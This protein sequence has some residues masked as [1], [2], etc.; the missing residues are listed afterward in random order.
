[1]PAERALVEAAAESGCDLILTGAGADS[2]FEGE[3]A[4]LADDLLRHPWRTLGLV[5]RYA[6]SRLMPAWRV[7][8]EEIWQRHR[9]MLR[10]RAPA[11]IRPEF[12]A[13]HPEIAVASSG[14]NRRTTPRWSWLIL[15]RSTAAGSLSWHADMAAIRRSIGD[16]TGWHLAEPRGILI[17]RPFLDPSLIRWLMGLPRSFRCHPEVRKL[18]LRRATERI[19]PPLIR[20]RQAKIPMDDAVVAG[21]VAATD[22]I[23][24]RFE[25]LPTTLEA[26]LDPTPL[27][28]LLDRARV[29]LAAAPE[30]V[31][32]A[33]ALALVEWC[34]GR[35]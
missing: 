2:F 19:L 4:H 1:M 16:R 35:G 26:V 5:R 3:P 34:R 20:D 29:G 22:S 9:S 17:S 30:I 11:W 18:L 25:S 31:Q 13:R 12:V 28:E 21:L 33:R 7:F 8:G 15:R 10:P 24:A 6:R 23:R 27:L 32:L 14:E